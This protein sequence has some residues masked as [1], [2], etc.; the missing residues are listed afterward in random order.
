M[1]H[2]LFSFIILI[3]GFSFVAWP[4]TTHS[5]P[6]AQ[7]ASTPSLCAPGIYLVDPQDCLALGPSAYITQLAAE[8]IRLPLLSLP[9]HPMDASLAVVPYS[10]ALLAPGETKVY[11]SLQDAMD[12][13]NPVRVIPDGKLRYISYSEYTDTPSGRFFELP[14]TTWVTV[15]SRVSVPHSYPGGIELTRT[16]GNSFG[17]ILPFDATVETKRTP[18]YSQP[19][20]TGHKISQYSIVQVYSTQVVNNEDWDLVAPGEWLAG[21]FVGKV[22]P[23]TTPPQGVENGR[24]IEINLYEQTMAVYENSQLV[25]ATL[26]ATGLEPLY[27]KPGLFQV[28]DHLESTTM[29]GATLADRSDFYYLQ[30]VPWTMYYDHARALHAAYWRTAFGYPQSH[31]CVNLSPG[32]AH[33]LFN[34]AK[35]G[36]W[37]YVWDPSGK[38]PTDPNYYGDGGA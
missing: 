37:V 31:G 22:T 28:R 29:S 3:Q 19:D 16:P 35:V 30:D 15:E 10:Y 9:Y 21:R 26:V 27:T 32:D 18:G 34:W 23:N 17:W 20:Y 11:P 5:Q 38:T 13:K 12:D 4:A 8:G 1:T 24:W 6:A 33:W 25:F 14:D 2:F 7:P 36:E